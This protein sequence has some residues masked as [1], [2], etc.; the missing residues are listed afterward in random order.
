M[1]KLDDP[2]QRLGATMFTIAGT[3]LNAQCDSIKEAAG[4]S[5]GSNEIM[6]LH[7]LD[8]SCEPDPSK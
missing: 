5:K 1:R 4:S 2:M 7:L 8:T 3:Q 6:M